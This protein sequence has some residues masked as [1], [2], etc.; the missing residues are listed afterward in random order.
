MGCQCV[1]LERRAL[2]QAAAAAVLLHVWGLQALFV[3]RPQQAHQHPQHAS[4]QPAVLPAMAFRHVPRLTN[5]ADAAQPVARAAGPAPAK[6]SNTAFFMENSRSVHD[7][8]EFVATVFESS[9]PP[10]LPTLPTSTAS[11]PPAVP[12]AQLKSAWPAS[13]Q[14]SYSVQNQRAG[15]PF[16]AR[17]AQATL[18][19]THDD[20]SYALH[21][22]VE[23][24]FGGPRSLHSTGSV[25]ETGL[26]PRRYAERAAT[27]PARDRPGRPGGPEDPTRPGGLE[28]RSSEQAVHF[29]A[30]LK[31]LNYSNNRPDAA[32]EPGMQDR[33]SIIMQISA[34]LAANPQQVLRAGQLSVPTTGL[35]GTSLWAFSVEQIAEA[36]SQA[37]VAKL[38]STARHDFDSRWE[39]WFAQSR[40]WLPVR[41]RVSRPNGDVMLLELASTP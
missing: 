34:W 26:Q 35:G 11:P 19:W 36:G 3:Q 1:V 32:L 18:H 7:S 24:W 37:M 40:A 8:I 28:G 30:E 23:R 22:Q 33:L 15:V 6:S 13:V 21:L 39:L 17:P 41:M 5:Q 27:G 10:A 20:G 4:Q 12:V 9:Q 31:R 14:L 38:S 29:N 16:A 25:G 2:W